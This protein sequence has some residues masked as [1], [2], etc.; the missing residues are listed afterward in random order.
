MTDIN[1]G[2]QHLEEKVQTF[3]IKVRERRAAYEVAAAT[4]TPWKTNCVLKLQASLTTGEPTKVNIMTCRETATLAEAYAWLLSHQE[5][6]NRAATEL[7]LPLV[8][9]YGSY[10]YQDWQ[11][12]LKNRVRQLQLEVEK[13][14]I[15]A[16][17]ERVRSVMSE[18]Q[19]RATA[20]DDLEGLLG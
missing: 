11:D 10:S 20:I 2:L 4:K 13:K 17:E 7:G 12:D 14:E 5:M 3:I 16:L 9:G 19:R 6:L 18:N 15:E 8:K 1:A